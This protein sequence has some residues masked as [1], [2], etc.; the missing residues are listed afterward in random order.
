MTLVLELASARFTHFQANT[1]LIECPLG[2]VGP[3]LERLVAQLEVSA[4]V[5]GQP[6][7]LGA[8]VTLGV[9]TCGGRGGGSRVHRCG[10]LG[11]VQVDV[12]PQ[13]LYL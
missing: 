10:L 2:V 11:A 8:A 5:A 13:V 3:S 6:R 4:G 7:L 9:R 12:E 1:Y